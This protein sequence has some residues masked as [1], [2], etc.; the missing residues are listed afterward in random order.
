MGILT[1]KSIVVGVSGG[2]A[3]YK[4]AELVRLLTASAARVRVMMTRNAQE[5]I[6][7]LTL[8]TLSMN[9][10]ATE[11]FSL[12]QE[13]EIGHI[14]LADTAD[15]IVIAPATADIIAKAAL[16]L[17]DDLV[18]TVLLAARC[19][20]AFAPAMNVHMYENPAVVENIAKLQSR[21]ITIVEPAVGELACGYEGRGRLPEPAFIVEELTRMLSSHDLEGE[22]ILVT[23]GPTQEAIDPVRFVSNR[24]TGKMGFA[25]ARAAWRRAASVR[26][27]A[28]PSALPTPHGVERIE[29]TSAAELLDATANNF[30]WCSALVMAAAVADFRPAQSALQ[31]LKKNPEGLV[32]RL[33][34]I[35]DELPRL[36][37][38]KDDRIVI[39]FAAETEDLEVNAADKL[40]RKR[41]DF[42]VANDVSRPDAGFAVDTNIVTIVSADGRRQTTPKLSKDEVGDVILDRLLTQRAQ[43]RSSAPL[44]RLH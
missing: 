2:I 12:T 39:G 4:A 18:T 17:A 23:A 43:R 32:L 41:L 40:Q 16:G 30:A 10:V 25:V 28:G 34:A 3:A 11:T 37:A 26:L 13:S 15:A 29:V 24:S 1:D 20:V 6:T 27:I 7:P 22:R 36:A 5:F 9:P 31:K 8:Q 21:G 44:E 14:R 35:A 19:P 33:T 38:Q 42:I